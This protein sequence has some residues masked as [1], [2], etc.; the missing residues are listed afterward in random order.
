MRTRD[1][2][3]SGI[4]RLTIAGWTGRDQAAVEAHIRELEAIGV[5]RPATTP[6]FYRVA[7]SLVT[8]DDVVEIL[9]TDSSGEIEPVLV[10]LGGELW[11]GVGSDHTDRK[12]ETFGVSLS[13]QLCAKP[14]GRTLWRFADVEDHWD[15][16]VLRSFVGEGAARRVYQEGPVASLRHPRELMRLGFEAE[17]FADG[18]AMM[19]GT[20][21][22]HGGF[23]T[24][25]EVF[26]M[27]LHDP[28]R[29]AT[30]AAS[31]RVRTLPVRG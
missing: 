22:V 10:A 31:Y 29:N 24:D 28:V 26:A 1:L 14:V 20:L 6:I 19:C 5:K 8:T 11:V 15:R 23:A 21:A 4:T 17:P 16:L 27:E 13:K 30:L 25:A 9:G 7:A 12:A 18:D 3:R 2:D